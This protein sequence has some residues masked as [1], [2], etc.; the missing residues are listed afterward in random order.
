MGDRLAIFCT[1]RHYDL[2]IMNHEGIKMHELPQPFHPLALAVSTTTV[3]VGS[4][5]QVSFVDVEVGNITAT[6]PIASRA[7]RLEFDE[8]GEKLACQV[9]A[10]PLQPI[11][12]LYV[13]FSLFNRLRRN[14]VH[15]ED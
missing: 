4:Y 1:F 8:Q 10:G 5:R 7:R 3:A 13:E 14:F 9:E 15:V 6:I 2:I 12:S 11:S